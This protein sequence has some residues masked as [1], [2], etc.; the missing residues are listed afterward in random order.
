MTRESQTA[1]FLAVD[2]YCGAGGTTRGLI[3]AGGYVVAGIDKDPQCKTTYEDNNKNLSLDRARPKYLEYD[4][5][6]HSPI[7][8]QGQRD[9]AVAKVEELL[10]EATSLAPNVPLL[11]A[12]C[13]PCQSFTKFVQR[14]LSQASVNERERNGTLLQQTIPFI[15][16]FKPDIILSENVAGARRGRFKEGWEHFWDE[17]RSMGYASGEKSVNAERFGVAQRRRRLIA[18]GVASKHGQVACLDNLIP[19]RNPDAEPAT[20]SG[21]IGQL[22]YLQ[23]GGADEEYHPNHRCR[24]LSDV[25]KRRLLAVEPGGSNRKLQGELAVPCHQRLNESGDNGFKDPYTRL[26][27]SKPAPTITTRFI[28]ISNG[29]FG[30]YDADQS[31]GL[32]LLEGALLQSFES[33]YVFYADS[34]GVAARMIGNAV[35]PK[36]ASFMALVATNLWKE[37]GDNKDEPELSERPR[38]P[39]LGCGGAAVHP[40][41]G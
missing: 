41:E 30:H 24:D 29:R 11:F 35:P 15:D 20:V 31:R 7:Y 21:R 39:R 23:A 12:I 2:F 34:S 27:P 22:P 32:S 33:D 10:T 28:S 14:N 37:Y 6:P 19:D 9:D 4:L 1:K 25:N 17:L 3:D 16:K 5:L 8:P 26:C 40:K 36:L 18:I 38:S 13:A